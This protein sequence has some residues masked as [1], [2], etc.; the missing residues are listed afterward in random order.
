MDFPMLEQC[1]PSCSVPSIVSA[2]RSEIVV[3]F[4]HVYCHVVASWHLNV[5]KTALLRE[6]KMVLLVIIDI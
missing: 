4:K 2:G 6:N 5:S 1:H 3:R